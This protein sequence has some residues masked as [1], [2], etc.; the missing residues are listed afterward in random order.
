MNT[1]VNKASR[2]HLLVALLMFCS[3]AFAQIK[4]HLLSESSEGLM[5]SNVP[6]REP[7]AN[8]DWFKYWG[9]CGYQSSNG[10]WVIPAQFDWAGPFHEGY[11]LVVVGA[12]VHAETVYSKWQKADGRSGKHR[13]GGKILFLDKGILAVIDKTGRVLMELPKLTGKLGIRFYWRGLTGYETRLDYPIYMDSEHKATYSS[14]SFFFQEG[15]AV[16]KLADGYNYLQKLGD[17]LAYAF[18]QPFSSCLPF[19]QG[20]AGVLDSSNKWGFIGMDGQW[21]IPAVYEE[22]RDFSEGLAAVKVGGLWGAIDRAGTMVIPARFKWGFTF[23]EGLAD[24]KDAQNELLIDNRGQTVCVVDPDDTWDRVSEFH[25]GLALMTSW[26]WDSGAVVKSGYLDKKG[27]IVFTIHGECEDFSNGRAR[28]RTSYG[29]GFIVFDKTKKIILKGGYSVDLEKDLVDSPGITDVDGSAAASSP[30]VS[31]DKPEYNAYMSALRSVDLL[32]RAAAL[33]AFVGN[34]PNSVAKLNALEGAMFAYAQANSQAKAA[35]LAGSILK[36]DPNHA[37]ALAVMTFIKRSAALKGDSQAATE[38]GPYAERGLKALPAWRKPN[39]MS[40]A[41]YAK[42]RDQ[43]ATLLYGGAGYN[44]LLH[45]DYGSARNHFQKALAIESSNLFDTYQLGMAELEMQPIDVLGFWHIGKAIQLARAQNRAAS[46]FMGIEAYGKA[47]YREY[48]GSY[49]GWD[50]LVAQAKEQAPPPGFTVPRGSAS[51]LDAASAEIKGAILRKQGDLD[52]AIY[53]YSIAAHLNPASAHL[54]AV[55]ASLLYDKGDFDAAIRE[56]D[57]SIRLQPDVASHYYLRG[58]SYQRKAQNDMALEDYNKALQLDPNYAN[59]IGG[60]ADIFYF[61]HEYQKAIAEYTAFLGVFPKSSTAYSRRATCHYG[62]GDYRQALADYEKA[63]AIEPDLLEAC[64]GLSWVLATAPAS[65]IRNGIM[66]VEYAEKALSLAGQS[67]SF[68]HMDT[69]AAAY[70]EAGRFADAIAMQSKAI[71]LIP[72][73]Y[74]ATEIAQ[75]KA[76][77][78]SYKEHK[79]WREQPQ[80]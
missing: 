5:A 20:L 10:E 72:K 65:G 59:A 32:Q 9:K 36:L 79:P 62:L 78:Q 77:L 2:C 80:R 39:G 17:S 54:H 24:V 26:D 25:E 7:R 8:E 1:R 67:A 23:S 51:N 73:D 61:T 19:S 11:A 66:A 41:D 69:L 55:L 70:A 57:E 71:S 38:V 28:C 45:K 58:S 42:A 49:E 6:S 27:K 3:S 60:R 68:I 75:F 12:D 63:I 56:S 47:K 37:R 15:R 30:P 44:A 18:S 21:Q 31:Q 16:V 48:H 52:G 34:Y 76:R 64:N 40:D 33:E 53:S 50:G 46:E 29:S 14:N 43:A 22:V 4:P 74:E 35:E 13:E